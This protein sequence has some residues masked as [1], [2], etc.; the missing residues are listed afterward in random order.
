FRVTL[1]LCG[2]NGHGPHLSGP[3]EGPN[4]DRWRSPAPGRRY[5]LLPRK[6]TTRHREGISVSVCHMV[7][8]P[9]RGLDC[10][11]GLGDRRTKAEINGL[12]KNGATAFALRHGP[13]DLRRSGSCTAREG[14]GRWIECPL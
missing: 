1:T 3:T 14:G 11:G 6:P 8:Q 13:Q 10:S 5:G 4:R 12:F 2:S 7:L 9:P